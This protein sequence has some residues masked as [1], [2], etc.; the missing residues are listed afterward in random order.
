MTTTFLGIPQQY[1]RSGS[2]SEIG[3][4]P[5]CS[6]LCISSTPNTLERGKIP[7][8]L[9]I[10]SILSEL[11]KDPSLGR[12]DVEQITFYHNI[13]NQGLQFSSVGGLVYEK[14]L[15]AKVGRQFPTEWFLQDIRD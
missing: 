10:N 2:Y 13:G 11:V 4:Q 12:T 5:R 14:A 8:K 15:K 7:V 6:R 9:A 1:I 3:G